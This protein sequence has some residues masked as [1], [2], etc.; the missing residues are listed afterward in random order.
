MVSLQ[1][2]KYNLW[3]TILTTLSLKESYCVHSHLCLFGVNQGN[4]LTIQSEIKYLWDV[5]W[6][7]IW[8]AILE[9]NIKMIKC[10]PIFDPIF[11]VQ[12]GIGNSLILALYLQLHVDHFRLWFDR[13]MRK[14]YFLLVL[15]IWKE[16]KREKKI[17]CFLSSYMLGLSCLF[18][19]FLNIK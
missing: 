3:Q 12:V 6:G 15:F 16:I 18:Y 8:Q 17:T 2:L 9:N 19:E 4:A 7:T 10:S 1:I 13:K 11:Y 14:V 5:L